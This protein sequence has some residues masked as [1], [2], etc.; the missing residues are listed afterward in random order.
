MTESL[1]KCLKKEFGSLHKAP[2]KELTRSLYRERARVSHD[3]CTKDPKSRRIFAQGPFWGHKTQSKGHAK[4]LTASRSRAAFYEL[5]RH[6]WTDKIRAQGVLKGTHKTCA[7]GSL[8]N[9]QDS[10][11][12]LRKISDLNQDLCTRALSGIHKISV[13]DLLDSR[14]LQKFCGSVW[15]RS[16]RAE[17]KRVGKGRA[18]ERRIHKEH[19]RGRWSEEEQTREG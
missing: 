2:G 3:L 13:Q 17:R 15:C 1:C 12:S 9:W 5:T 10:T 16:R 7:D 6:P 18:E 19:S 11:G 8:R 4:E 14:N